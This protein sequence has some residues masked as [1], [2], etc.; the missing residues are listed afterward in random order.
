MKLELQSLQT[1][2]FE[3]ILPLLADAKNIF[4]SFSDDFV[5]FE[6]KTEW[7]FNLLNLNKPNHKYSTNFFKA[8]NNNKIIT[9]VIDKNII[10]ELE[11]WNEDVHKIYILN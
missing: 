5:Q 8:N 10:L 4:D 11:D 9:H 1:L 3:Q 6:V 7:E 2:S